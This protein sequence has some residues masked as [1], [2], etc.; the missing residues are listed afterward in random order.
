MVS[1]TFSFSFAIFTYSSFVFILGFIVALPIIATIFVYKHLSDCSG[2]EL[3]HLLLRSKKFVKTWYPLFLG[4]FLYENLGHVVRYI[5]FPIINGYLITFDHLFL[6]FQP[7]EAIQAFL[8]PTLTDFFASAYFFGY[9]L[10]PPLV[11]L[12]IYK[13]NSNLAKE[14]IRALV[15]SM[16]LGF[17]FYIFLPAIQ[18]A[19]YCPSCYTKNLNGELITNPLKTLHNLDDFE[20]NAFPSLHTALTTVMLFYAFKFDKKLG[21]IILPISFSVWVSTLYLRTHYFADLLAAWVLVWLIIKYADNVENIY[22]KSRDRFISFLQ[23]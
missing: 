11:G 2:K 10:V 3:K 20:A 6:G 12:I 23:L 8:N 1:I 22:I 17:L 4:V 15:L 5:R 16:L 7:S 13:Y 19:Y 18:P 21:F 14:Y 9:V